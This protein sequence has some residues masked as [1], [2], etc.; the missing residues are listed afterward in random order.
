MY[1]LQKTVT[2][3]NGWAVGDEIVW[4]RV[5]KKVIGVEGVFH[6]MDGTVFFVS[7]GI[8]SGLSRGVA[9]RGCEADE[10]ECSVHYPRCVLKI[11]YQIVDES[12]A[13]KSPNSS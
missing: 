12:C 3:G 4:N 7:A 11:R 8:V 13:V 1:I 5:R 10:F 9:I 2:P 6:G